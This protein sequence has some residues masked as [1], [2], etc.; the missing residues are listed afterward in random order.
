MNIKEIKI[1]M[2]ITIPSGEQAIV[3]HIMGYFIYYKTKKGN[4]FCLVS[5]I[6]KGVKDVY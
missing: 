1:G 5:K 3:T 4:D 6:T 2:K